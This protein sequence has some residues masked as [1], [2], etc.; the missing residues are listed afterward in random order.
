MVLHSLCGYCPP[1]FTPSFSLYLLIHNHSFS[2]IICALIYI[3]LVSRGLLLLGISTSQKVVW[4]HYEPVFLR[5]TIG[6]IV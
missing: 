3:S 6:I 2:T 1:Y 4:N 5:P